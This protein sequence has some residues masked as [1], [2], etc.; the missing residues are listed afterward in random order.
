M[1]DKSEE[2][3]SEEEMEEGSIRRASSTLDVPVTVPDF[4]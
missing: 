1:V 4:L 2:E 3:D